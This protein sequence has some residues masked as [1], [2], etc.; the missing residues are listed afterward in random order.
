[1]MYNKEHKT[2]FMP[3]RIFNVYGPGQ[4]LKSGKLI[5]NAIDKG[6]KGKPIFIFGKGNQIMDFIYIDDVI[7]HLSYAADNI[8]ANDYKP[9]EIGTG[10]GIT[11]INA[12]KVIIKATGNQSEIIFKPKRSGEK[13][14]NVV[15]NKARF[16]TNAI[17]I[18]KFEKGIIKTVESI[19][20]NV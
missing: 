8:L 5:I 9:Y 17:N 3:M 2:K 20:V 13:M 16:I 6:L 14:M 11:I 7:A 15:A 18:H 12:V 19:K 4:D 1:M 10:T